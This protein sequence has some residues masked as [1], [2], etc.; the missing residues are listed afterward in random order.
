MGEYRAYG[1]P[2]V[3]DPSRNEA[4]AASLRETRAALLATAACG[5]ALAVRPVQQPGEARY[6][7]RETAA[8]VASTLSTRPWRTWM[9]DR[10]APQTAAIAYMG[11]DWRTWRLPGWQGLVAERNRRFARKAILDAAFTS[12][13]SGL[14]LLG[15]P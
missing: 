10:N 12:T 5:H 8:A 7:A 2:G 3:T 15:T 4:L 6:Q 13:G 9:T 11:P 14:D 1:I